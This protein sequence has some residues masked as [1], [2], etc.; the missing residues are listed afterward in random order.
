MDLRQ[1]KSHPDPASKSARFLV[2]MLLREL[3]ARGATALPLVAPRRAAVAAASTMVLM[4]GRYDLALVK[5]TSYIGTYL[6]S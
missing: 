1:V 6:R 4:F 5:V 2:D 3:R